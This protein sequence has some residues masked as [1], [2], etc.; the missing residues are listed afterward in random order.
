MLK[1]PPLLRIANAHAVLAGPH[2][3]ITHRFG[4]VRPITSDF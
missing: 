2:G 3:A 1:I 4:E